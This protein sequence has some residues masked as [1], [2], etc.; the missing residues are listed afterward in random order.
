[1]RRHGKGPAELSDRTL[2]R[3]SVSTDAAE[4]EAARLLDL[5]GFADDTLDADD[6]ER[7]ADWLARDAAAAADVVAA[8]AN[9]A[10][11]SFAPVPDSIV[12]HALALV[13]GEPQPDNI[14]AFPA[15]RRDGPRLRGMAQW[16]SLAAAV[17]V[18]AWLGLTLG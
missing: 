3:R 7:I 1:M 9:A 4:D 18:A 16:G 15:W 14:V 11:E 6:R 17:A 10:P 12:A 13:G 2:W 8:R 5:A